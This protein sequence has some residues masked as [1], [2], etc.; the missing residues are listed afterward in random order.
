MLTF[1]LPGSR[2]QKGTQSRIPDPDPKHWE[3]GCRKEEIQVTGVIYR[4][5]EREKR[6]KKEMEKQRAECK[7]RDR[8]IKREKRL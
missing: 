2:G 4:E 6:R 8:L 1:S 5:T 3:K 7:K